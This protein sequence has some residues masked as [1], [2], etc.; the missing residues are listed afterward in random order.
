MKDRYGKEFGPETQKEIDSLF[1]QLRAVVN[2]M[3]P[4]KRA[5]TIN[6]VQTLDKQ[7]DTD[8]S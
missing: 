8:P 7:P 5:R 6:Y 3:T 1:E 4:E 2:R